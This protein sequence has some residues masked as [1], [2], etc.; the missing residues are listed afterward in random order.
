MRLLVMRCGRCIRSTVSRAGITRRIGIVT[1]DKTI[2]AP[3]DLPLILL[4]IALGI[5]GAVFSMKHYERFSLHME[6]ARRY[7]D[8]LDALLPGQPLRTLK[9]KADVAHKEKFPRMHRV[10]ASLLVA[11][12]QLG[13]CRRRASSVCDCRMVPNE[14]SLT[15]RC[16]RPSLAALVRAAELCR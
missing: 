1:F 6:R 9:Q 4:L 12:A 8:A 5:F 15:R 16:S 3:A 7:R 11:D 2:A 13:R 14:G 10:A